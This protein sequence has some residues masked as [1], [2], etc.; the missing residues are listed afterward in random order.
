MIINLIFVIMNMKMKVAVTTVAVIGAAALSASAI[1]AAPNPGMSDI[2]VAIAERFNLDQGEVREFFDQQ[3]ELRKDEMR[4]FGEMHGKGEGRMV[5][6]GHGP[7]SLEKAVA[8]GR[9]TQEQADAISAKH[10][11]MKA[12]LEGLKD[13]TP[14][15]RKAAMQS[16]ADSLKSWAEE[17]NIPQPNLLFKGEDGFGRMGKHKIF[18]HGQDN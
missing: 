11:E 10:A 2:V 4:A 15:E 3:R 1:Y 9:L 7:E 14:E 8:E 16:H 5:L 13:A 6:L 18:F 12:L 17:N